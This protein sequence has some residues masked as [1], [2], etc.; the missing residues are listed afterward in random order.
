M[1]IEISLHDDTHIKFS[2][3]SHGIQI[4]FRQWNA[5]IMHH[6]EMKIHLDV[7]MEE[8]E[9]MITILRFFQNS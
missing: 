1:I 2:E 5:E 8:L 3:D 9:R 4:E 7:E 6:D